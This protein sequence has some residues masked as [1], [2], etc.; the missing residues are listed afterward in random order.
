VKT[1]AIA[2]ILA[3]GCC[4]APSIVSAQTSFTQSI[5][6]SAEFVALR[7]HE[8]HVTAVGAG[9]AL[10]WHVTPVVAADGLVSYFPRSWQKD[11]AAGSIQQGLLLALGGVRPGITVGRIAITGRARAGVLHHEERTDPFPCAAVFPVPLECQLASGYTSA[12]FDVGADAEI[13]LDADGHVQLH[14]GLGD[15][16]VRYGLN[17][18]RRDGTITTGFTSHDPLISAGVGWRF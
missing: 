6:T 13:A 10:T 11:A 7:L 1:V 5:Q 2:F 15:L 12:A 14:A 18:F 3:G 17:A 8:V 4:M 16:I 9:G